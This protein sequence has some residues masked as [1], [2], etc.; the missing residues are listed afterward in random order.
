MML[1]SK[2]KIH[3]GVLNYFGK[4]LI[5][6]NLPESEVFE[7]DIPLYFSFNHSWDLC[8]KCANCVNE[9]SICEDFE[10]QTRTFKFITGIDSSKYDI[11]VINDIIQIFNELELVEIDGV[12]YINRKD[13]NYEFEFQRKSS[14]SLIEYSCN[15]C[16]SIYLGI[17]RCSYPLQPEKNLIEG[18]LGKVEID[19]IFEVND[20]LTD[21]LE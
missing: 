5:E 6:T 2:S 20:R 16:S 8:H 4:K 19:E 14:T 11:K 7:L 3:N 21:M 17:M 12:K 15:A 10:K 13:F 18:K 9:V 1:Y